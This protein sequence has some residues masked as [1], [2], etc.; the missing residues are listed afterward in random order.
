M[1]SNDSGNINGKADEQNSAQ[2]SKPGF[3]KF[4]VYFIA[5]WAI[6]LL[7]ALVARYF[8]I[9][10]LLVSGSNDRSLLAVESAVTD[11]DGLTVTFIRGVPDEPTELFI[12]SGVFP[13]LSSSNTNM[14]NRVDKGNVYF[15]D[16]PYEILHR[17]M[18]NDEL[19]SEALSPVEYKINWISQQQGEIRLSQLG[20]SL[21][22]HIK[23]GKAFLLVTNGENTFAA[24][25][26]R[27]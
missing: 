24:A 5:F 14:L 15:N 11:G 2:A 12:L 22:E 16:T 9:G 13:K 21:V 19:G 18:G 27:Y 26:I 4:L 7:V 6:A 3:R 20:D 23:S 25:A 1:V 8:V 10:G 17:A